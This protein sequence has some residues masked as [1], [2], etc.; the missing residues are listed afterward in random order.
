MKPILATALLLAF[1]PILCAEPLT[2]EKDIQPILEAKCFK[3]HGPENRRANIA[4]IVSR[5]S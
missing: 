4:W 3:C 5:R 1:A 2:Y